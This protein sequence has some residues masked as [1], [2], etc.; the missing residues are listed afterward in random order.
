MSVADEGYYNKRIVDI[1]LY[2]YFISVFSINYFTS[3][4]SC[5]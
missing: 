5:N 3:C 1:E 4:N 2:I